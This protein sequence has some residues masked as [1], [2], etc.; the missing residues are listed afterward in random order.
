SMSV[1]LRKRIV[2]LAAE[3]GCLIVADETTAELSIDWQE[4][5]PPLASFGPVITVGS[6]AKTVWGGLRIGWIRAER[7]TIQ[8]LVRARPAG[9]LGTPVLDQLLAAHMLA[10]FDSVLSQRREQLRAGRD[11]LVAALRERFP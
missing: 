3:A 10:D 1:S 9:D 11:H 5:L 4:L 6:L 7:E 8:R 2:A